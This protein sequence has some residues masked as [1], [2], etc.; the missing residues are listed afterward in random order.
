M[1]DH[2]GLREARQATST[3]TGHDTP[4]QPGV[5][6]IA[7]AAVLTA[8]LA[9]GSWQWFSTYIGVTLL[10]VI[11]SFHRRAEAALANLAGR[12][13]GALAQAQAH[14]SHVAVA[15]CLSAT[16]TVWLPLYGLGAAVLTGLGAWSLDRARSRKEAVAARRDSS[17]PD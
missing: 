1:G 15:D 5:I 3:G 11:F 6:G 16:T 17:R 13:S 4:G 8:T 9:Q 14:Q 2:S 12:D 7:L 10:A